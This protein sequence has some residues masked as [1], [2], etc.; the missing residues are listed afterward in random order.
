[1]SHR[2]ATTGIHQ[3]GLRRKRI[4]PTAEGQRRPRERDAKHMA[5]IAILP[6]TICGSRPVHV[7]HVRM[8]DLDHCKPYTGKGEKPSDRWT[9]PLC[10]DCH[11]NGPDAQHKSN[12]AAWWTRHGIDP[13]ALCIKLYEASGDLE[14]ME[15]IILSVDGTVVERT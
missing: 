10:P 13:I 4:L 2:I 15:R 12:E 9:L 3:K 14:L 7:A 1:M 11:V 6:C 8:A 5:C